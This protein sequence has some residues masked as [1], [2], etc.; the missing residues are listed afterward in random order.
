MNARIHNRS[1][2]LGALALIALAAA[3]ATSGAA[4]GQRGRVGNVIT[5]EEIAQSTHSNLFDLVR[6]RRGHWFTVR[7][8]VLQG[9]QPDVIVYLG[10]QRMGNRDALRSMHP[11]MAESIRFFTA[12]EAEFRFG[13]GHMAGAIQVIPRAGAVP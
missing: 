4:A 3:C 12:S 1:I 9:E 5:A 7:A 6:D 10:Q 8:T 11:N 2:L 13:M